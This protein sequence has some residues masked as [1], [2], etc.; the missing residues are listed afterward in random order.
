MSGVGGGN[1][2][3]NGVDGGDLVE[4]EKIEGGRRWGR[5]D[6]GRGVDGRGGCSGGVMEGV[7]PPGS[8]CQRWR[9]QV[10]HGGGRG[11]GKYREGGEMGD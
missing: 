2:V 10:S 1:G 8:H 7:G 11:A 3:V 6:V 4:K 9:H 5:V